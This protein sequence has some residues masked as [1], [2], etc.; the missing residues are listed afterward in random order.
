MRAWLPSGTSFSAVQRTPSCALP[1]AVQ[2]TS[3]AI[4]PVA[5]DGKTGQAR[6]DAIVTAQHADKLTVHTQY[7][8]LVEK[9]GDSIIKARPSVEEE[10]Q[11][12]AR[13]REALEGIVSTKISHSRPGFI[14]DD[15]KSKSEQSKYIRYTPAEDASGYNEATKQRIVRVVEAPIDPLA[16]AKFKHK[17]VPGGPPDAP[18]PIMHSP[19][20]KLTLADQQAWTIP[21]CVSNWKNARG[22]V[23]PL[24]KRL[25]AD[26]RSLLEPTINDGFAK[27]SESL[28]IA[29]R[30]ARVEVETRAAI[31]KKLALKEKDSK[32]S[33][34]RA[35][36]QQA[37]MERGGVAQL[38]GGGGLPSGDAYGGRGGGGGYEAAGRAGAPSGGMGEEEEEVRGGG[39]SVMPRGS[40]GD[41][42]EEGGGESFIRPRSEGESGEDY[43]AR[44]ERDRLRND[45]KRERER[46]LR[47]ENAP[48]GKRA[49]GGVKG[50]E[51]RDVSEKVALGIPVGRGGG[52]AVS[53]EAVFDS[54]LFNQSEGMTS[55]L[56]GDDGGWLREHM[57]G[58]VRACVLLLVSLLCDASAI[59][60]RCPSC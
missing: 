2:I 36:A 10:T 27:F 11:A 48:A 52:G 39:R 9:S 12:A 41:S 45:R 38:G 25:A 23:V 28:L 31:E 55:G 21:P 19:P 22:Y 1:S 44:L 14:S 49:R 60:V 13:T 54:R 4:V 43:R 7:N 58:V 5:V 29:E 57:R 51:D 20:R 3:T 26:G 40:G 34:L 53:T 15:S 33:E 8:D 56:G 18:V 46:D 59:T 16:P 30:K 17:K 42:G 35:M 37:R 32:E 24:D 6:F 47:T 50:D